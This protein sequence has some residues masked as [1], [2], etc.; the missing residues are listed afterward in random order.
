MIFQEHEMDWANV[1]RARKKGE[2]IDPVIYHY[3][4]DESG[5][6]CLSNVSRYPQ[7]KQSY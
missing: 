2:I 1:K 7:E 3:T 6:V 4:C 5:N